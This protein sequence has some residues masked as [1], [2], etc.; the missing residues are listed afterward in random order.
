MKH[1]LAKSSMCNAKGEASQQV[2]TWID[3]ITFAISIYTWGLKVFHRLLNFIMA[4]MCQHKMRHKS[5]HIIL[6]LHP[7]LGIEKTIFQS[8]N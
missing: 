8:M 4:D 7:L 5:Y 1:L 2:M 3:L 6:M